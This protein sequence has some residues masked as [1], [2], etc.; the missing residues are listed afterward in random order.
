MKFNSENR[1]EQMSVEVLNNI[2]TSWFSRLRVIPM[3]RESLINDEDEN[4]DENLDLDDTIG[5]VVSLSPYIEDSWCNMGAPYITTLSIYEKPH[6]QH[7]HSDFPN[8]HIF[9]P[10]TV[11]DLHE[12][13]P[14]SDEFEVIK[15]NGLS[16][17]VAKVQKKVVYNKET[18]GLWTRKRAELFPNSRKGIILK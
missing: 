15:E 1:K 11:T 13:L 12:F 3:V 18:L 10:E 7:E 5:H 4:G 8:L 6:M 14:T 16:C 9:I 17:V 2:L